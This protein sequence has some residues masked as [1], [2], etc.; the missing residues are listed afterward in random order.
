MNNDVKYYLRKL[1]EGFIITSDETPD[2]MY[3]GVYFLDGKVFHT[4]KTMLQTGCKKVI[5]QQDQIDFSALSEE[6]Q[7]KIGWFDVE[8]FVENEYKKY[9]LHPMEGLYPLQGSTKRFIIETVQK[10][11]ELLSD[12]RFTLEDVKSAFEFY[13]FASI[14]QQPYNEEELQNDFDIFIQ[15]LFQKSWEVELEMVRTCDV[16][17]GKCDC[18]EMDIDCQCYSIKPITHQKDGRTYL[19]L[20]QI[21]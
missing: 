13:S 14:S 6:E 18:S 2:K 9:K 16:E 5:A 15:S 17:R 8:K 20:K 1:P 4:D 3:E 7:K 10:A 19:K 21:K 11:R 12:R